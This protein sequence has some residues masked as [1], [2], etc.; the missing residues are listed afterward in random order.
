MMCNHP[1]YKVEGGALVCIQCGEPSDRVEL[2]KGKL[3]RKADTDHEDKMV[4][5]HAD[6]IYPP[7]VKRVKRRKKR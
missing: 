3:V 5:A 7:E 4:T 6:K 2:V 1:A